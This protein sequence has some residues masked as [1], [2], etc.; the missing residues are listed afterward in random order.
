MQFTVTMP[1]KRPN[2]PPNHTYQTYLP[3]AVMYSDRSGI[4][5]L[6]RNA[7]EAARFAEGQIE[8]LAR[9]GLSPPI[10]VNI[11]SGDPV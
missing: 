7:A 4:I 6:C 5:A 10:V 11:A 3:F 8:S 1:D 9:V 2:P